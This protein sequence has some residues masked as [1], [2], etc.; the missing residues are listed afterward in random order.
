[1]KIII[2]ETRKNNISNNK[3][4]NSNFQKIKVYIVFKFKIVEILK[5][6][7]LF[8]TILLKP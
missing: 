7:L 2:K 8:N 4:D 6:F 1:M 5:P 3:R